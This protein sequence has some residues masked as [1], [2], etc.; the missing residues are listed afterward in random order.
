MVEKVLRVLFMGMN[1][2]F[3]QIPFQ[4]LLESPHQTVGL[5]LPYPDRR[6]APPSPIAFSPINARS[7]MVNLVPRAPSLIELAVD[8]EIPTF[9]I[10][11]LQHPEAVALLDRYAPDVI[12]VACF[13]RL[14]PPQWLMHPSF[15]ALNLHPS[16]LPAYRGPEPLFWQFRGGEENTGITLHFMDQ[17]IDTG[18]IVA[19]E[20]VAFPDGIS[21]LEAENRLARAGAGLILAA[22]NNPRGIYRRPQALENSSYQSFPGSEDRVIP[23]TWAARQAFNFIRGASNWGPFKIATSIRTF[24]ISQAQGYIP[25]YELDEDYR[26][27]DNRLL[28]QFSPGVLVVNS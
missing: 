28:I 3:S 27:E 25:D 15:G 11:N 18:D 1:G 24:Q 21:E 8:Y 13:P 2:V 16:L 19:Q 20:T 12:I 23:I 4:S 6:D 14:L 5:V 9:E 10:G 7:P 26:F 22:L 17:G